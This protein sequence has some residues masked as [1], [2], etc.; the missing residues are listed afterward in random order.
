MKDGSIQRCVAESGRRT[1]S[2]GWVGRVGE[3]GAAAKVKARNA[4]IDGCANLRLV[5]ARP[6]RLE[7][8]VVLVQ[9]TEQAFFSLESTAL[10][11]SLL[12][13]CVEK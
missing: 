4:S 13:G 7:D 12:T 2:V 1:R 11:R 3:G 8:G 10:G 9:L 5:D 6:V